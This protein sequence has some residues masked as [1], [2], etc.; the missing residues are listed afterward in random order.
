MLPWA[1]LLHDV[2]KPPTASRDPQTA[3][4]HF[5]GHERIGAE[6][7]DSLLT[8][9]RFPRKQIEEVMEAVRWHMQFKDAIEMRK[10][11][12]RRLLLRPTFP[13]ELEL[14]RLDCLGS[15]R[16]LD[17]YEF[18]VEKAKELENQPEIRPPLVKGDD[19]LALGMK[20]GP[21]LGALLAEI[22][23]KQL[24]DELKTPA[25]AMEW[26]RRRLGRPPTQDE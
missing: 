24:Q 17:V 12:L 19:L 22:R 7:T 14:H 4:I 26:A 15:H 5:Y 11:T 6:M 10:A 3:S 1:V 8:R 25:Q 20:P 23:E 21:A 9:L 18:L 2:A 13:L 16:R